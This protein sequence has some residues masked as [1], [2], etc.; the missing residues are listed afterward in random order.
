MA[1]ASLPPVR[2]PS[3]FA[4]DVPEALVARAQRGESQ[5]LEPPV[6]LLEGTRLAAAGAVDQGGGHVD[7]EGR[8]GVHDR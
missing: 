7:G 6:D 2:T 8:G 5:A 3:S 1:P 4:I